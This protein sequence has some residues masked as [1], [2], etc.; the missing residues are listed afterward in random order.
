MKKQTKKAQM[1]IQQMA[2]MLIAVVVF[3]SLIGIVILSF[4]FSDLKESAALLEERNALLLV[5][6]LSNSPEFSC[7][8]AFGTTRVNCVDLD[9]VM[10]LKQNIEKYKNFWDVENIEIRKIYP[11]EG[12]GEI[13]CNSENYPNCNIIKLISDSE[14]GVGIANFV[15]LCRKEDGRD[16]CELG[17]IIVIY[18]T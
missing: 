2:F 16:K 10:V 7:G 8:E 1:K 9:K 15:S 14:E 18:K 4:Q 5:T 12:G 3:F 13:L 17:K 6:K 11:V